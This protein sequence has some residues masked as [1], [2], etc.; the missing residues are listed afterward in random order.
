MAAAILKLVDTSAP[1]S[2]PRDTYRFEQRRA[3]RYSVTGRATAVSQADPADGTLQRIRSLQLVNMSDCGIGAVCQDALPL[4][5]T[6]VVFVP[7]HGP[8]RGMDYY[9]RVA[10]CTKKD[11]GHEIG[12]HF[13][14]K[15]AA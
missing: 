13:E 3:Q 5:S 12:I 10:R 6:I 1:P 4:D 7:P 15:S 8:E 2:K 14:P 9:G 11:Y